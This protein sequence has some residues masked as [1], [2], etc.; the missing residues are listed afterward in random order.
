V[1]E[2]IPAVVVVFARR[3]Q[4]LL[5]ER[6]VG[7]Y[8]GGSLVMADF[9]EGSSD[10]DL[11]VVVGGDLSSDDLGRLA[12]LHERLVDEF[13]D[14][15][16][17][18]GDYV[19]RDALR[20][21]G[22]SRPVPFFRHGRVEPEPDSMLSADNI[23][24]MRQDGIS[25]VGPAPASVLP[26]V[27]AEQV[28]EAVRQML[29]EIPESPTE[30]KAASEI[31]DLVRSSRALETGAPA[32]KSEGLRWGLARLDPG[33]A[34]A[35]AAGRRGAP[36]RVDSFGR[37]DPA[38]RTRRSPCGSP[39]PLVVDNP[40]GSVAVDPASDLIDAEWTRQPGHR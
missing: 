36:R 10:Y 3:L 2:R 11:L 8:L 39:R 26:E 27:S 24:N 33:A 30:Q 18:E 37:L 1:T 28:R 14:A 29:R 7:V 19:P 16:C 4:E 17:L 15:I 38:R 5:G 35:S 31:L 40:D 9:V 32:T 20:P 23:A 13:P 22:T 12:A 6:L 21:V 34:C 25:V